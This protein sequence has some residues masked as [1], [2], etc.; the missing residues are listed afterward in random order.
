MGAQPPLAVVELASET[1]FETTLR[2]LV[3][4]IEHEGLTV[5]ARIDHAAGARE[6]GLQMPPTVLLLYGNAKGGTPIM[7]AAPRAALDLPLRVLL[8]EAGDRQAM[9][10]FHPIVQVLRE[11]GV[12]TDLAARLQP[13]QEILL[14][15]LRR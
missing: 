8:R 4:V 1:D 6:A 10:S 11:A 13:A 15:A 14:K 5:F 12:S 2:R 3:E 9:L 7:V